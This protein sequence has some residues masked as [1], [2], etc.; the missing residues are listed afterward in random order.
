MNNETQKINVERSP[1]TRE[2]LNKCRE[3]A[4]RI[5][6]WSKVKMLIT[7]AVLIYSL[8]ISLALIA[9]TSSAYALPMAFLVY[10][11]CV[12]FVMNYEV[13]SEAIEG[14]SGSIV[15]LRALDRLNDEQVIRYEALIRKYPAIKSYHNKIKAMNRA[16]IVADL[17]AIERWESKIPAKEARERMAAL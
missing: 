16:P 1:P 14:H 15:T 3:Q 9:L 5:K 13:S 12:F 7:F 4:S 17:E 11:G 6:V 8:T 2:D 10:F